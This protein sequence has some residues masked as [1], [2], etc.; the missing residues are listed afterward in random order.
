MSADS[1]L[2]NTYRTGMEK[3]RFLYFARSS[4]HAVSWPSRQPAT[5]S[6]SDLGL[7]GAW[8]LGSLALFT[9]TRLLRSISERV[10]RSSTERKDR[11]WRDG[12]FR[13]ARSLRR[14]CSGSEEKYTEVALP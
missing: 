1:S 10:A 7:A 13:R 9:G 14:E 5:N 4:D 8:L 3:M 12:N 2:E 6:R 11:G